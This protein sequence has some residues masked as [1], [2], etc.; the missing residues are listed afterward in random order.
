MALDEDV[1]Q[2]PDCSAPGDGVTQLRREID[3]AFEVGN[4]RFD[5]ARVRGVAF[6]IGRAS[7][8]ERVYL[9]V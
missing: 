3:R 9:C 1:A 4:G 6:E 5:L 2:M 7:C 8:R